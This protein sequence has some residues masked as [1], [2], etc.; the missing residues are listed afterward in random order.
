M[1]FQKAHRQKNGALI[2]SLLNGLL[3]ATLKPRSFTDLI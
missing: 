3:A 2:F 1:G